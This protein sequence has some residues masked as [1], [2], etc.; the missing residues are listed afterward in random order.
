MKYVFGDFALDLATGEL[1]RGQAR[2]EL[3]PK[4]YA[5]LLFLIENRH[6]L[7]AKEEILDALW[8]DVHVSDGVLN[9]TVAELR[10]ILGDNSRDSR[11]IETVPRRG[12]RFI[13]AVM[14]STARGNASSDLMLIL[15]DRVIPLTAGEHVVGRTPECGIQIVAPSVSR[16]HARIVVT[17]EGGATIEDLGSTNGTFV[18]DERITAPTAL[19]DGDHLRIGKEKLR[20]VAER[21]LRARTEPAL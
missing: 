1:R 9:R 3:R 14:A 4:V 2:V 13:A 20:V 15:S 7:V 10:Q 16:R 19:S 12:Y 17:S 8:S 21:S 11:L 6:R 5:L 18:G